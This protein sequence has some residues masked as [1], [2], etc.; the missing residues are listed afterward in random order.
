M[1]RRGQRSSMVK[2]NFRD[3]ISGFTKEKVFRK[4]SRL[5]GKSSARGRGKDKRNQLVR[6]KSL[7]VRRR[8]R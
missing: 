1:K 3:K 5:E 2:G 4:E 6:R 7:E 8:S